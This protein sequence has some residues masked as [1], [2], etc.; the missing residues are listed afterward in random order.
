MIDL[1]VF[2]HPGRRFGQR[3][4]SAISSS[5]ALTI[6]T[7]CVIG[8]HPRPG[9]RSAVMDEIDPLVLDPVEA[10][11]T[12]LSAPLPAPGHAMPGGWPLRSR[13]CLAGM[14]AR[15]GWMVHDH[16]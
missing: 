12:G 9:A 8:A 14:A 11:V 1:R 16:V 3:A 13:R 4:D 6:Y 5:E 15:P 7:R 2:D 10:G